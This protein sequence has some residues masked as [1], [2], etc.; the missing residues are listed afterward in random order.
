MRIKVLISGL[1]AAALLLGAAA[2]SSVNFAMAIVAV[3]VQL[4][5]AYAWPRMTRS[6]TPWTLSVILS[7]CALASTA[8]TLFMPG[9][10]QTSHSVEVIA[11]GVL[12]IFITQVL[13]GASSE[14]RLA[15]V[16][17]GVTGL[18]I[19][20]QGAGWAAIGLT[21]GAFG[22]TVTTLLALL[23]AGAIAITRWPDRI[24]FI[25]APVIGGALGALAS[26]LTF[27]PS[28][29]PA[30]CIG[31]LSGL[32]VGSLRALALSSRS[33]RTISGVLA[34]ACGIL[35]LAGALSWYAMVLLK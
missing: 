29:A 25:L 13:R 8:A 9:A 6:E 5:F 20:T 12:L 30:L 15:G 14:G 28:W 16:V 27:G 7:I 34:L 1:L 11:A 10:T 21:D 3:V 17:S 19:V 18:A 23:G 31:I 26:A 22:I 33:V 24:T 2:W 35:L 32:L 4:I